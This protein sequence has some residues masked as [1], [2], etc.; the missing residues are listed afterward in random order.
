MQVD[1]A[2]GGRAVC[3]RLLVTPE[4]LCS[5][6]LHAPRVRKNILRQIE[7]T[8]NI[9]RATSPCKP[10][11]IFIKHRPMCGASTLMHMLLNSILDEYTVVEIVRVRTAMRGSGICAV[12][13]ATVIHGVVFPSLSGC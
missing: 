8:F 7:S 11:S 13:L 2:I 12:V 4:A 6:Q 5:E 3:P 1:F 10:R 9:V